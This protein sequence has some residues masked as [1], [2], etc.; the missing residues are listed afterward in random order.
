MKAGKKYLVIVVFVLF[1]TLTFSQ[2]K[3]TE[4]MAKAMTNEMM[5][6]LALETEKEADVFAVH[7]E[8][9]Q[10]LQAAKATTINDSKAWQLA[11]QKVYK[12]AKI[13]F[14]A[15]FGSAKYKNWVLY[16]QEKKEALKYD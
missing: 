4:E 14:T 8:K 9:V 5:K 1:S 3:T 13:S 16:Q 10:K 15:L 12:E 2:A 7:F 11:Q 6:V